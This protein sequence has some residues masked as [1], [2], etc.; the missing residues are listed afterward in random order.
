ML[1][2]LHG[3]QQLMVHTLKLQGQG[4]SCEVSQMLCVAPLPS[5]A[6]LQQIQQASQSYLWH[7]HSLCC[8]VAVPTLQ[9]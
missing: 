2:C 5:F 6:G 1:F 9:N 8:V 7:W 3:G 4:A